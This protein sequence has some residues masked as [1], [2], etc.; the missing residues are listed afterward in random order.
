MMLCQCS[1]NWLH[2]QRL[3]P[4]VVAVVTLIML[5]LVSSAQAQRDEY[6]GPPINYM[7]ADVNDPVARL[8]RQLE[9]G[10]A[11]L[12]YDEKQGYLPA[13]LKALDIPVSSQT[14]VF[15]KTSL[16]R[17]RI[18]PRHPRAI[19]FNDDVYVGYCQKGDVLEFAATEAKQEETFY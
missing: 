17:S 14:L 6:S 8:A 13:V 16:Q 19:Y 3:R 15:S 11:D 2:R 5:G 10:E 9:A 18:S 7:T 4:S 1:N 12:P